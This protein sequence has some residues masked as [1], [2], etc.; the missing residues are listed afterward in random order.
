MHAQ[1]RSVT[2]G[3]LTGVLW[4]ASCVYA[5]SPVPLSG[6]I[7]G[8]VKNGAGVTQM[9]A[10]V[11]LYNR[12]DHLV[13]QALTTEEGKFAFDALTPDLY[14]I[15]V[16]LASFVPAIRRNIAVVPGSASVLQINLAGLL[17]SVDLVSSAPVR[18][19][20]MSDDWKWVLRTSQATRPVLRFLPANASSSRSSSSTTIFSDT[21]GLVKLSA[22]DGDSLSTGSPQDLGTAFALATS[23]YGSARVQF[24][25]NFGYAGNSGIPAGGFRTTYSPAQ[26]EGTGPEITLTVRQIYLPNRAGAAMAGA[27]GFPSLRTMSFGLL[28]R[29]DLNDN[30]HLEYGMSLES[31][32]FLQRLNYVSPFARATY[33]LDANSSLQLAYSSGAEPTQLIAEGGQAA[34]DANQS[35][36]QDLAAL[37]LFPRVSMRA[38]QPHVQRTQTFELGYRRVQGSRTYSVGAYHEAVSNA[39]F[40]LSAPVGFVPVSDLMPNFGASS[41]IFNAGS[42]QDFGY[43]ASVTQSLGDHVDTSLAVG[44]GGA[45]AVDSRGAL[46]NDADGI[47]ASIH[48][49]QREWA[50]LRISGT[51]PVSGTRVSTDYGWT[52]FRVLMPEHLFLT[53]QSNLA[54]GWNIRVRQPLPLFGCGPGRLEATIEMRNLLA[55]GYLPLAAGSYHAVLTNSPRALR[56]GLSF[57]F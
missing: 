50:S 28:D 21:T 13:R 31:V 52:D 35:F 30:L 10:T 40:I 33:D 18:G 53:Q 25:G 19:T 42:Y 29:L 37:A 17:S 20:L 11:R 43:T 22:G 51:L 5:G 16:T 56:G 6:G 15:R 14:S 54:P 27:D 34:P 23:I 7:L 32:S 39:A 4:A 36:D 8:L 46:S 2:L 49:T 12:Y 45:L 47:R 38:D 48:Q 26:P 41:S 9:G 3:A 1:T 55:Q 24:S 44:R 57:I